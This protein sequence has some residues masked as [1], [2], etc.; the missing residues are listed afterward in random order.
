M[1]KFVVVLMTLFSIQAFSMSSWP[2]GH[3]LGSGSII[4]R[5]ATTQHGIDIL[6]E[7]QR[8]TVT[9][10]KGSAAVCTYEIQTDCDSSSRCKYLQNGIQAGTGYC[11]GD[12]CHLDSKWARSCD[13][14]PVESSFTFRFSGNK[15]SRTGATGNLD[16][17]IYDEST[18]Q[19]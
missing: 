16:Q 5:G 4:S 17:L 15:L 2:D 18:L 8:L 1:K 14:V 13:T 11:I 12:V 6:I 3:W 9:Y 10:L 19:P 7:K